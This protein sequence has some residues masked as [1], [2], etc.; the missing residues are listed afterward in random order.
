M[1]LVFFYAENCIYRGILLNES[2]KEREDRKKCV[3]HS[4]TKTHTTNMRLDVCDVMEWL[5]CNSK[6]MKKNKCTYKTII[7]DV[8]E[9]NVQLMNYTDSFVLNTHTHTNH[10]SNRSSHAHVLVVLEHWPFHLANSGLYCN[11]KTNCFANA[12]IYF[13]IGI[14]KKQTHTTHT[15]NT[16]L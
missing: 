16:K 1:C 8:I 2:K 11:W 13:A 7:I 14:W 9:H 6:T 5:L 12:N 10:P 3:S 15:L 4:D